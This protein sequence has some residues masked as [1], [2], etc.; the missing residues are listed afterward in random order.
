M[1]P[2][3]TRVT[4]SARAH[5]VNPSDFFAIILASLAGS[6]HCA[7]MCGPF[8]P[9]LSP[10]RA[11]QQSSPVALPLIAYHGGRGITYVG[12]GAIA[13]WAGE[14]LTQT[15]TLLGL[16]QAASIAMA[17][18]LLLA[19]LWM[20]WPNQKLIRLR[21][22][23]RSADF[24]NL[25]TRILRL[26]QRNNTT[27]FAFALGLAS[28]LLPCGWLWSYVT[29]A[30]T[31]ESVTAAMLT[32]FAFWLGTLPILTVFAGAAKRI[33][34]HLGNWASRIGA[35]TLVA[36]ACWTLIERWPSSHPSRTP[37]HC[38]TEAP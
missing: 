38:H 14:Y 26:R 24:L 31:R 29:L 8:L 28:A 6:L 22:S 36:L 27:S 17:G 25:R 30:A 18:A 20:V 15:A 5:A 37:S 35:L 11:P 32:T 9:L 16:R 12:L 19:A 3:S 34:L 10:S 1:G 23:P 2:F 13:G 21:T 4:R 7:A 33:R